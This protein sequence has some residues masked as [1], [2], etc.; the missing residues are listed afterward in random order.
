MADTTWQFA[1]VV[2]RIPQ[3]VGRF[4]QIGYSMHDFASQQFLLF[5]GAQ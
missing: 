3:P 4:D 2:A 5:E 1:E